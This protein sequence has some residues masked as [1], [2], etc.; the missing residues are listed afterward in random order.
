[1][2]LVPSREDEHHTLEDIMQEIVGMLPNEVKAL[3]AE[4]VHDMQRDSRRYVIQLAQLSRYGDS[5]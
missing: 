4:G 5:T 2:D 3:I 1:M